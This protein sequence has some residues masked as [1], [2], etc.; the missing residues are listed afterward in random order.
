MAI[1]NSVLL[2]Q[3]RLQQAECLLKQQRALLDQHS[4]HSWH[5]NFPHAAAK[6]QASED[7][8]WQ[9]SSQDAEVGPIRAVR[10]IHADALDDVA[11]FLDAGETCGTE[12]HEHVFPAVQSR[13]PSGHNSGRSSRASSVVSLGVKRIANRKPQHVTEVSGSPQRSHTQTAETE[14]CEAELCMRPVQPELDCRWF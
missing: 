1:A 5:S 14:P 7:K 6:L 11:R 2:L 8:Y 9:P 4:Q 3:R 12:S 13:D 10:P